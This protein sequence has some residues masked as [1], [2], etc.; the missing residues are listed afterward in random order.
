M[1][2]HIIGPMTGLPHLNFPAFHAAAK[3]LRALG[4]EV[5]SAAELFGEMMPDGMPGRG[6]PNFELRTYIEVGLDAIEQVDAVVVLKGF[7]VSKG[8]EA[9]IQHAW[10]H[11]IP[12]FYYPRDVDRIPKPEAK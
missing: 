12:R 10:K 2:L 5:T 11:H 3:H 1:K 6:V 4:H 7:S 8:T 9:E